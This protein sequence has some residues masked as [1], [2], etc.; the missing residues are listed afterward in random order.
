MVI[1]FHTHAFP[2]SLAE[3]AVKGLFESAGGKYNPCHNGTVEGIKANMKS[4]GVDL[5]VVQP[6]VTKHK[7]IESLN[8][9]AQS[10]NGDG[11][12]SFGGI[13]PNEGE[14][15]TDVDY[16]CSLGLK[17]LKF[18]PEY[19][20][21]T[22]DTPQMLKIYD[23]ALNK[24][25]MLLFH[26]GFDIAFKPPFRSNPKGFRHIMDEMRGG[27]IIAAHMGGI[28]EWDETAELLA[29]TGIY[30]DTSMG[31]DEYGDEGF[32]KM[33]RAMGADKILF[34]SD[35]PW[36]NAGEEIKRINALPLSESEKDAIL[37]G[38]AAKLLG[39]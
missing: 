15:K 35:A 36:S 26:A 20:S 30:L 23:Y 2:D 19:Q 24:G 14:F 17:G 29:G 22:V 13:F 3:R 10:I 33:V 38:N 6:V 31:F 32:I 18:H 11:I 27:V 5:S 4:F 39:L 28:G 21:F 16:V 8:R 34:G 12:V 25:L 7:Q 9:W 37:G 1:D